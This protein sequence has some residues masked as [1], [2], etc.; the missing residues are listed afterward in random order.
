MQ[1]NSPYSNASPF[2]SVTPIQS[3]GLLHRQDFE[4]H[5]EHCSNETGPDSKIPWIDPLL[6]FKESD[7]DI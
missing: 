4:L 7:Q 6:G 5:E 1:L 2:V 3:A